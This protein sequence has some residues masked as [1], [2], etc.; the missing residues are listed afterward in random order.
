MDLV[1]ISVGLV[2]V[3]GGLKARDTGAEVPLIVGG[4]CFA[5]FGVAWWVA[6]RFPNLW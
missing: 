4:G 6:G 2:M 5:L 3:W 1:V